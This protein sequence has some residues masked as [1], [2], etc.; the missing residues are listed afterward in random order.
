LAQEFDAM[1][2][3]AAEV[4]G[5]TAEAHDASSG[6]RFEK[7]ELQFFVEDDQY[8]GRAIGKL[9]ALTFFVLI[10]LVSG[11][12]WWT[13]KHQSVSDD[14]HHLPAASQSSDGH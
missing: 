10:L 2:E 14:P 4:H 12:S 7:S 5:H 6:M 1:S 8:A 13:N 9:L 3:H 11:V